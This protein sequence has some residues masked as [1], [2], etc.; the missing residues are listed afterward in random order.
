MNEHYVYVLCSQKD[1]EWYIGQ[2]DRHPEE[3]LREHNAGQMVSTKLRRPLE[4]IYYEMYRHKQDALGREKFLKSGAGHNF[5]RK[6]LRN[7][8][9]HHRGVEQPGSSQGS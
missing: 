9:N 8:L 6:Q 1:N 7:F 5:V 4:L 2:T 3:R